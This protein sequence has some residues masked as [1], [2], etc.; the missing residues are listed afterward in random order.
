MRKQRPHHGEFLFRHL[1][2]A[3]NHDTQE[4]IAAEL[5]VTATALSRWVNGGEISSGYLSTIANFV[6]PGA[7]SSIEKQRAD[8]KESFVFLERVVKENIRPD[9]NTPNMARALLVSRLV[10]SQSGEHVSA[11]EGVHR[12]SQRPPLLDEAR[13]KEILARKEVIEAVKTLYKIF[14][15][16]ASPER[17]SGLEATGVLHPILTL[18]DFRNIVH[19]RMRPEFDIYHYKYVV[20]EVLQ[21]SRFEIFGAVAG[22][23]TSY[24]WKEWLGQIIPFCD[25]EESDR[26]RISKGM[27]NNTVRNL[28]KG[29]AASIFAV[30]SHYRF[31]MYK[32]SHELR[33]ADSIDQ[34][35]F[36]RPM[37]KLGMPVF[38]FHTDL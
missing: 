6:F 25:V 1:K 15:Q 17:G 22:R 13:T 32:S 19:D 28:R 33:F 3:S 30:A 23:K 5:N 14:H 34:A 16:D 24:M 21:K 8:F 38:E 18:G 10:L 29:A 31:H 27:N 9:F 12:S 7:E 2:R 20:S 26:A 11:G 37:R 35:V 36:G 4:N